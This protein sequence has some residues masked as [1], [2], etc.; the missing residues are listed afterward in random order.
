[1]SF[2]VTS[3]TTKENEEPQ[4]GNEILQTSA[5]DEE[6]VKES[7]DSAMPKTDNEVEIS[8]D[9]IANEH[10]TSKKVSHNPF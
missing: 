5:A 9:N 10:R 8:E 4:T 2:W 6:F 3:F 7:V 1:M